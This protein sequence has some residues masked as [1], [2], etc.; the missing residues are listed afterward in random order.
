MKLSPAMKTALVDAIGGLD[1]WA[2]RCHECSLALV[3]TGLLDQDAR[4]ARGFCGSVASQHSWVV[5]GDPYDEN[6]PIV[7]GTLW[8]YTDQDPRLFVNPRGNAQ[9][10][11]HGAGS[12]WEY[13]K[14][15]AP[16][17]DVIT[18]DA[19]L[20]K[21]AA[22]FLEMMAPDGLDYRGWNVIAHAP[23]SGWP[24]REIIGAMYDDERLRALIPVDIV[25]MLTDKNPGGLYW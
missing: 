6:A 10:T 12:I 11:P 25:G 1:Q 18:L 24:A 7:D 17:K 19:E 20:P 8:S 13:G 23:V 14:P 4:V 5:I 2:H 22:D 3:R 9:Y 16:T 21:L 15:D